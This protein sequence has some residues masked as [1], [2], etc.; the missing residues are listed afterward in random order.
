M[1]GGGKI[2][3]TGIRSQAGSPPGLSPGESR[4]QSERWKAAANAKR[5]LRR[6]RKLGRPLLGWDP[7]PLMVDEMR[8][9]LLRELAEI[10]KQVANVEY[11]LGLV[12]AELSRR[13]L[14]FSATATAERSPQEPDVKTG[15]GGVVCQP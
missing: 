3:E 12:G 7:D 10:E 4:S 14:S 9:L 15:S 1:S 5:R 6:H 13:E 11:E 2:S 8:R